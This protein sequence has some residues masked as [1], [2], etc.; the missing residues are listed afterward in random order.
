VRDWHEYRTRLAEGRTPRE[1]EETVDRDGAALERTW[2]GLRTRVGLANLSIRQESLAREW[3][4]AGLARRNDGHVVLTTRG[5]LL[6]D[7]LAVEMDARA[8][9]RDPGR[10]TV[11]GRGGSAVRSRS[12]DA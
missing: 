3:E 7:R 4:S 12:A 9:S 1:G 8:E 6:L 10:A 5:W 2:L 11:P